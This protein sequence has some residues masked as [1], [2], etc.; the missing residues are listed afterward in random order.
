LP[1]Y[2]EGFLV[3]GDAVH[4]LSPVHAQ[5]MTAAALDS[6]ALEHCLQAQRRQGDLAG[7]ARTF[8]QQLYEATNDVWHLVTKEDL[9]WPATEVTAGVLPVRPRVPRQRSNTRPVPMKVIPA[10]Y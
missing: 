10:S 2:L 1:R 5:G 7:L 6:Q 9:R 8:Q 4:A 3:C